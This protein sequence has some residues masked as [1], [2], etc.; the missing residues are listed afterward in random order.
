MTGL[1]V[2][3]AAGLALYTRVVEPRRLVVRQRDLC[4]PR[5]PTEL[6]GLKVALLGDL[7]VGSPGVDL[8]KV[9]RIVAVVRQMAPDLVLL[10]GDL[11]ADVRGGRRIDPIDVA[12]HLAA[13]QEIAPTWTVL[14]NHDWYA[15]GNRV[16]AA[17]SAVGLP[18]LE[19]AATP[20]DLPAGTVWLAGVGDLW[21]RDP[22]PARALAEVPDEA[23]CILL[24]HNPDVVLDVPDRVSLTVAGHTHSGQ[25]AP[26][27]KPP[28][29]VSPFTGNRFLRGHYDVDGRPL[30]VTSGIGTSLVAWRLGVVPE[31]V[32]LRLLA[33][34]GGEC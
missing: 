32:G 20:V 33:L 28:Y 27:G 29:H 16:L 21:E 13:L 17:M 12:Q 2:T 4:L 5:W 10:V 25:V 14:G 9:R 26:F 30:Y 3:A 22:S 23:P 6:S 8:V 7:H 15:G 11:V 19:E 34:S 31:V 24:T 18:V 1:A